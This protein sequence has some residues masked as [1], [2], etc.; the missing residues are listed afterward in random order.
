MSYA[1]INLLTCSRTVQHDG[2][3][4]KLGSSFT[5]VVIGSKSIAA[6]SIFGTTQDVGVKCA[7][8]SS[9]SCMILASHIPR[10][11]FSNLYYFMGHYILCAQK[12]KNHESLGMMGSVTMLNLHVC[13]LLQNSNQIPIFWSDSPCHELNQSGIQSPLKHHFVPQGM[14]CYQIPKHLKQSCIDLWWQQT[15]QVLLC[16]LVH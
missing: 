1:A 4:L 2:T 7:R 8:N 9:T 3:N 15:H 11:W 10:T 13:I 12:E 6:E 5:V 16:S 14:Q